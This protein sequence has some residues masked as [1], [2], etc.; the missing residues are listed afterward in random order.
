M[1]HEN[2][3]K[4]ILIVDNER[5]VLDVM[6][7]A[8]SYEGYQTIGLIETGNIIPEIM[9]YQPDLVILDYILNGINGGELCHQLKINSQTAQLP[10][11][12]MSAYPRVLNSLGS[13][14]CDVFIPKPFNLDHVLAC[15]Q[16]LLEDK[17]QQNHLC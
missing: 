13:Y 9:R 16:Q 2:K 15:I 3:H 5:D 7:E 4:K 10:V 8:L 11:I 6:E 12:I 1:A 17:M 14:G